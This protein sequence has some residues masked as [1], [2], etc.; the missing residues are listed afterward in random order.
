MASIDSSKRASISRYNFG[1]TEIRH[2]KKLVTT[3]FNS[4]EHENLLARIPDGFSYKV[5]HVPAEYAHRP[6]LISNVFYDTPGYWWFILLFNNITDPLE[7]LNAGDI[8]LIP[9]I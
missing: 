6:D 5:G 9:E 2:R 1:V 3:S 4:E 7:G 8:V